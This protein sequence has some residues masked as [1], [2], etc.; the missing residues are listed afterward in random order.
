MGCGNKQA[1]QTVSEDRRD[2]LIDA[3]N[4]RRADALRRAFDALRE[5]GVFVSVQA[6]DHV[7]HVIADRIKWTSVNSKLK[8]AI[9]GV[10]ISDLVQ[11]LRTNLRCDGFPEDVLALKSKPMFV[12][13]RQE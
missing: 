7:V 9:D 10:D 13:K 6:H 11:G 5:A 4:A 1:R 3:R 2:E 8:Y 12:K